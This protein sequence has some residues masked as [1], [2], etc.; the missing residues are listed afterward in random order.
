MQREQDWTGVWAL[1]GIVLF[2]AFCVNLFSS[3]STQNQPAGLLAPPASSS[4]ELRYVE[5]RFRR[6][7]YS[8]AESQEAAAA[9]MKF[10]QAQQ[11]R[12]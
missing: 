12:R 8:A 7:G 1:V 5:N 4:P 11:N 10:Q 2:V 9:V 3:N 6:E